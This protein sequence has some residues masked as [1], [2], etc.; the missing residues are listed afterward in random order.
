MSDFS[1]VRLDKILFLDIETVPQLPLYDKLP[2]QTQK[3][4]DKKAARMLEEG[5]TAA[6]V[7]QRA[8]IY[9]EFG[10]IICIS[11]GF[12]TLKDNKTV[13]RI[14]SFAGHDE[15][16]VIGDFNVMV[17][18]YFNSSDSF[19]CAHNGKEFD[20]PYIARRSLI[21]GLQIPACLDTRG[22]KPWEVRHFDTLELWRF[23]DFKSYTSLEL[24]TH[25]F[26][27]PTPKDDISGDQVGCVYWIDND[28]DRIVTYCQKDVV[29]IIQL[30]LKFRN[31]PLVEDENILINNNI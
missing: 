8:G 13:I 15:R 5:E 18:K 7:Y 2:A 1:N 3:L 28:I 22:L 27:I 12:I 14:K 25:I 17:T 10:K 20:F 6:D 21:L 24:L 19:L 4:W 29:A 31:M 23:G 30:F 11:V 9:S 16:Q 26:D